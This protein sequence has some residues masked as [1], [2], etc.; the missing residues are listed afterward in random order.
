MEQ[1]LELDQVLLIQTD[2]LVTIRQGSE[3]ELDAA[4]HSRSCLAACAGVRTDSNLETLLI[5]RCKCRAR[6]WVLQTSSLSRLSISVAIGQWAVAGCACEDPDAAG[7]LR[8]VILHDRVARLGGL[9][10]IVLPDSRGSSRPSRKICRHRHPCHSITDIERQLR[11]RPVVGWSPSSWAGPAC[12]RPAV[13][14]EPR[15]E[16]RPDEP[17]SGRADSG[18]AADSDPGRDLGEEAVGT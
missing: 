2:V 18:R 6:P 9:A 10:H 5:T 13:I 4:F 8:G 15:D 7:F 1:A 3:P 17:G 11:S 12:S 16:H 14:G